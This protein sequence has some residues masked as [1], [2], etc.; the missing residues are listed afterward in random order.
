MAGAPPIPACPRK[1][2][3]ASPTHLRLGRRSIMR[4]RGNTSSGMSDEQ[5]PFTAMAARIE[6]NADAIFGGA[7]VIVPPV[8][9]G[10]KIE[11]LSL[12]ASADP[13]LFWSTVKSQIEMTLEKLTAKDQMAHTFGRPR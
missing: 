3:K 4:S 9:G 7:V 1:S 6:H 2:L 5:T 10:D 13:V 8:N 11:Y 12:N